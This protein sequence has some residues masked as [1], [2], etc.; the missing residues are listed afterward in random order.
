MAKVGIKCLTYAK[1]TGGGDGSAVTYSGG[2]ML[3]D[4]LAR[5]ELTETRNTQKEYA[6]DHQIDGENC[7]SAVALALELVNNNADIKKDVL[8]HVT[9]TDDLVVTGDEAPFVGIGY[10]MKNRFKGVIT[11]E[12][13]WI[14]KIQFATNGVAA[15][16]KKEQTAFGHETIN[17]DGCGVILTDGGKVYFYAHNDT[18]TTEAAAVNWLKAKAGITGT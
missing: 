12:T 15:D 3:R 18:H 14:Y 2:K 4:Y 10:I 6:D 11:Y 16:T 8:G 1:F 5:A 13:Y 7:L 17:G 9:D